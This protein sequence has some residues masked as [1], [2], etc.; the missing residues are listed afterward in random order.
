LYDRTT[1]DLPDQEGH[2]PHEF[3]TGVLVRKGKRV[4]SNLECQRPD[5]TIR[6]ATYKLP[7]EPFDREAV[8]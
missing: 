4:L 5:D 6:A 3:H 2:R 7:R 8:P 1:A